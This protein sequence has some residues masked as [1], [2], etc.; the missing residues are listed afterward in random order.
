MQKWRHAITWVQYWPG[1]V[2]SQLTDSRVRWNL[3]LDLV[4]VAVYRVMLHATCTD[5]LSWP[6]CR[7]RMKSCTLMMCCRG[8]CRMYSLGY[9]YCVISLVSPQL[10]IRTLGW[11]LCECRFANPV[12][13][14]VRHGSFWKRKWN[15]TT[16]IS[17]ILA[18]RFMR[19]SNNPPRTP[20]CSGNTQHENSET[21]KHKNPF[22]STV[23]IPQS[24]HV[25]KNRPLLYYQY[26]PMKS[27]FLDISTDLFNSS[28]PSTAYIRHCNGSTSIQV[29]TSRLFGT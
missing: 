26:G 27:V 23:T 24:C 20:R 4:Y 11:P 5:S 15:F 7:V 21:A 10:E 19:I 2:M 9:C 1:A 13:R 28:P 25:S 16:I 8:R 18:L 22:Q 6:D 12:S 14:H 17:H 3:Y 29:M